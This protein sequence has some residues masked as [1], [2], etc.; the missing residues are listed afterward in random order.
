MLRGEG[1]RMG[2]GGELEAK[3]KGFSLSLSLYS[4]SL[5]VSCQQ[6]EIRVW[7]EERIENEGGRKFFMCREAMR[8]REKR[9]KRREGGRGIGSTKR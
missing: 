9:F 6:L 1:K 5:S 3:E 4:L 2:K 7:K 8:E